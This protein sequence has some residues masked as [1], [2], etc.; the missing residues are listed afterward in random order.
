MCWHRDHTLSVQGTFLQLK[1][2][3]ESH[4]TDLT[5]ICRN[6]GTVGWRG[7]GTRAVLSE[8]VVHECCQL[9]AGSTHP[10]PG[11]GHNC[12]M[13]WW[14]DETNSHCHTMAAYITAYTAAITHR[15]TA[16]QCSQQKCIKSI[17]YKHLATSRIGIN[18][19]EPTSWRYICAA[20]SLSLYSASTNACRS[21]CGTDT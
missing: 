20:Y 2:K 1:P 6:A 7:K 18:R 21:Y 14:D 19:N 15:D 5:K 16:A 12:H 8:N 3:H 9:S 17:I 4:M 10:G 11:D 13:H